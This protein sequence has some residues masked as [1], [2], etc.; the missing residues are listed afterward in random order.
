[1]SNQITQLFDLLVRLVLA[2]ARTKLAELQT[3]RGRFLI[4]GGGV[5][6]LFAD[7]TL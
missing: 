6:L 1:L 5:V 2:A 7:R 4:L 3:I